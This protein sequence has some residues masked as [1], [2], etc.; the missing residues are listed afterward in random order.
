MLG[1][2]TAT[3]IG[4]V[5][6]GR[7]RSGLGPFLARFCEA[8]GARVIGVTGSSLPRARA[9]ADDFAARLGHAVI[10]C[11]D[12]AA[13]LA[14][15]LDAVIIA[16]PPPHHLEALEQALAAGVPTL[17]EKPLVA[18]AQ[19][20][21]GHAIVQA[22]AARPL[23]LAENCQWP[24]VLPA[25]WQLFPQRRGLSPRQVRMRL[26]PSCTGRA[27]IEDSLPHFLSVLQALWPLDARCELLRVDSGT[28][29]A[30]T[31][32]ASLR[33]SL[34]LPTGD[35]EAEL[36]LR[37]CPQQPRPAW[38][39]LDGDRM[40]RRI[41]ADYRIEFTAAARSV[42]AADPMQLLVEDF[43]TAVAGADAAQQAQRT[44]AVRW[45][46]WFYQAVLD[47]VR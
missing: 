39:E 36:E 40:Q 30:D 4:I 7:T 22:F 32:A 12:A 24:Y 34:R 5:G 42:T 11:G 26:S 47:A 10:G 43:L 16:S 44:A 13:L 14:L 33:L 18:P 2:V 1:A 21:R 9:L 37:H 17:C 3:R 41:G 29:Q 15:G 31:E 38:L 35:V 28:L 23:L 8:A 45:R 6:A 19:L 20:P 25:F 46:L 27:M